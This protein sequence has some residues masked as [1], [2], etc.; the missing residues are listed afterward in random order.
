M[1]VC[2][3]GLSREKRARLLKTKIGYIVTSVSQKNLDQKRVSPHLDLWQ[4]P[5]FDL[6]K[7]HFSWG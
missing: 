1:M 3:T 2:P 6:L 7:N 4:N 5:A